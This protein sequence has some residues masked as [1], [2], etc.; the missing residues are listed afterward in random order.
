MDGFLKQNTAVDIAIG[1]FLDSTDGITAET[2]LTISQADVRLKKNN[3]AWAQ[4]ND[5]TAATHEENGWYEKEL[6]ATDTNTLGILKIAVHESGAL[7][8]FHTFVVLPANVYDSLIS[9]SDKLDVNVEEWNATSV[10]AED[11][12][13]YPKVTIKSGTGTGEVSLSGGHVILQATGLDQVVTAEPA[14]PPAWGATLKAGLCWLVALGRNK[15]TQTST[16][17]I[18]RNDADSGTIG[19]STVSDDGTTFTRGEFS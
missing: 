5:N 12:A 9:G 18:L 8:V 1:P 10:P 13:G 17:T 16:T 7:P 4:V 6:D 11:T 2:A 15:M 19:T 14:G 3:G